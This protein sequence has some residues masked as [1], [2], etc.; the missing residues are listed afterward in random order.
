MAYTVMA[1]RYGGPPSGM[2]P[3]GTRARTHVRVHARRSAAGGLHPAAGGYGA[4]ASGA[5]VNPQ[6][7]YS[8]GYAGRA[9]PFFFGYLGACR[10][11]MPRTRGSI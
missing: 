7:G 10:R 9:P 3:P 8:T 5:Q 6:A 1:Y 11:R 2:A 4:P